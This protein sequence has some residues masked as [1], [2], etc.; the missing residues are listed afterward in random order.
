M[1]KEAAT[2]EEYMGQDPVSME[3]KKSKGVEYGKG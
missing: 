1:I 3:T 2:R